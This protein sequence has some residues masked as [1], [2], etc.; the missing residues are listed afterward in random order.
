MT[1]LI[2][3]LRTPSW[4]LQLTV[5]K[6]GGLQPFS[7]P[8]SGSGALCILSVILQTILSEGKSPR[9][10]GPAPLPSSIT[11][12]PGWLS[13][14]Q[15]GSELLTLCSARR[16]IQKALSLRNNQVY[17]INNKNKRHLKWHSPLWVNLL[18]WEVKTF[19]EKEENLILSLKERTYSPGWYSWAKKTTQTGL[20]KPCS[21]NLSSYTHYT[22]IHIE[23]TGGEDL[24]D[25]YT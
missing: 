5:K 17:N 25:S 14:P 24:G 7:A 10:W 6:A 2:C 4:S 18:G 23:G 1:T 13:E 19:G 12:F 16:E 3:P 20:Y 15:A 21:Y 8:H 9:K 22:L 11:H